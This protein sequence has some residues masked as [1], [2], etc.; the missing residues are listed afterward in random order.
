MVLDV[1]LPERA[2]RESRPIGPPTTKVL[3]I[4]EY[5]RYPKLHAHSVFQHREEILRLVPGGVVLGERGAGFNVDRHF[6]ER[7]R[8]PVRKV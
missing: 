6:H 3:L 8:H 4:E 1:G 7:T 5:E 2:I